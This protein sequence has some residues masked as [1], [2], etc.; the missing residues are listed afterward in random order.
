MGIITYS[1]RTLMEKVIMEFLWS[2][3]HL[4]CWY[5]GTAEPMD[6]LQMRRGR[7]IIW[8]WMPWLAFNSLYEKKVN[9]FIHLT[10][11]VSRFY[12]VLHLSNQ[13]LFWLHILIPSFVFRMKL[14]LCMDGPQI[15]NFYMTW[16]EVL[17]LVGKIYKYIYFWWCKLNS[18]MLLSILSP[19]Q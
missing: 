7:K 1:I 11:K 18:G 17:Y 16:K 6:M 15:Y 13:S 19:L 9:F 12:F 14:V 8:F 3:Y 4:S 5:W 2:S 10:W